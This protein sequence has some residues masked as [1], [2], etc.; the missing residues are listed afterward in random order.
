MVKRVPFIAGNW[1]MNKLT[2]EAQAFAREF[3]ALTR[4]FAGVD[5][6][7]CA[8]F[9]CLT[10]LR[11]EL[12]G[13]PILLG[14]QN[15][16]YEQSGAYTGEISPA[17]ILDAGCAAVIIGHSER[18]EI[19]GE[20]DET[21][22]RKT[23]LA[24]EAGLRPIVCVGETL[25]VREEK[26]AVPHVR[27]QVEK[28]LAGLGPDDL[29]RVTVAYEPIWAIGTGR[30]A[31]AADAQEICA[32]VRGT[33]AGLAGAAAAEKTRVLYGGS[34]KADNIA[35][36]LGTGDI[37]GALVGGASL[38]AADFAELIRRALVAV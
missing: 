8:P 16:F 27:A 18:R 21:V 5:I 3:K 23:R 15:M 22:A 31:T 10:V 26:R 37:D 7:I 38:N 4:E 13:G 17:M 11:D 20:T 32:L 6:A 9:T 12:Q 1:K 30:T 25:A 34:V 29:S 28:A 35:E 14:A 2:G 36:L 24:L 19:I 33:I